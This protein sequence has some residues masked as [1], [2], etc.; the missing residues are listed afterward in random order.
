[1]NKSVQIYSGYVLEWTLKI[2]Y[3]L[4]SKYVALFFKVKVIIVL[5][6]GKECD[7]VIK[8]FCFVYGKAVLQKVLEL[9]NYGESFLG[10]FF[11]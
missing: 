1:M 7:F 9:S 5:N 6:D 10:K 2:Y 4:I 3:K 11:P 8:A